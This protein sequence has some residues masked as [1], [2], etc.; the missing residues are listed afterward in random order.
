MSRYE[1][2][3][4]KAKSH[5]NDYNYET[6]TKIEDA[7]ET[8]RTSNSKKIHNSCNMITSAPKMEAQRNT[9]IADLLF[10]RSMYLKNRLTIFT[11]KL[12]CSLEIGRRHDEC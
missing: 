4:R 5:N 9:E 2:K 10:R 8:Q 6:T 3:L 11:C 7:N 1:K 12:Y